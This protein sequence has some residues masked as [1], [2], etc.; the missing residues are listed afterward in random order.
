M[1]RG[2]GEE[3]LKTNVLFEKIKDHMLA[4][5][6]VRILISDYGCFFIPA[7]FITERYIKVK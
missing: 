3:T 7:K 6:V 2:K 4:R 1:V 5:Q